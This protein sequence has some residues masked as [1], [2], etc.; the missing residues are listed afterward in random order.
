M[1]KS[2]II[3][4]INKYRFEFK[5][6]TVLFVVMIFF[7][8]ILSFIQ[9]SSLQ[10]FLLET[11]KSYQQY[12]AE[13]MA[14]LTSTSLE[15]LL[16]NINI[17]DITD[18]DE[19]QKIIQSFN[20]IFSQQLLQHNVEDICIIVSRNHNTF[21]IDDGSMLF[22]Y[23]TNYLNYTREPA[24]RHQDAVNRYLDI[25]DKLKVE[26]KIYS[27]LEGMQTFHIFVPFVPNGEYQ[28]VV[29]LKKTPD[30]TFLTNEIASSYDEAAII[31]SSLILLGLL[32]MYYISSYTVKER[33][34]VQKKFLVE[35]ENFIKEQIMH[36]KESL[37]TKRIY[38]THHK[39]E[40]IMGFIKEDLRIINKD[41]IDEIKNRVTK[42]SN[43]ISRVIYDMKWYDPP[44][45]TLR[46]QMF[47]TNVNEIIN[48]L[49]SHIF[50]RLSSSTDI[51]SFELNLDNDI[52]LIHINEFVVWEIFEP[53]IQNSIDHSGDRKI[54]INI[55]SK[56]FKNQN[57]SEILISDDG[58]G[59]P[60]ELLETDPEGVKKIFNENVS[61]KI[62][63]NKNSGYGCYIAH[64]MA[65]KR[66]G[67]LLDVYN[68]PDK[69]CT[70]KVTIPH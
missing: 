23:L 69:G 44:I 29:Y 4:N 13:K 48:F 51:F 67:W 45:H 34:E 38:H 30:F 5:H 11:Q 54:K 59:I 40:K 12:S 9:K 21:A 28:G 56:Y 16:E 61:T 25:E 50:L 24:L 53:L 7:Q 39:A 36:E 42:Y 43:F 46:N 64:Q 8:I 22:D 63:E 68:N 32:T 2:R 37:F 55:Q 35:H 70:F 62:T 3:E 17:M 65:T 33:D 1:S 60:G 26:E 52:P 58:T 41:N 66:C 49:T 57:L 47:N 20:I 10:S 15:L 14:N 18:E 27:T 19:K 31:Y 6:L